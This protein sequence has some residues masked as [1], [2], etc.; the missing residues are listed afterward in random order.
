MTIDE[1]IEYARSLAQRF[2]RGNNRRLLR[3]VAEWLE[4]LKIYKKAFE[5]ACNDIY[6]ERC[7][8]C[9]MDGL[10]D[11]ECDECNKPYDYMERYL[12]KARESYE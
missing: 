1:A 12:Q 10:M 2:G 8:H 6:H 11:D 3:L 4:E 9:I 5:L 7:A